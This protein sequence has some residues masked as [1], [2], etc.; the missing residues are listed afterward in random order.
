L[1][2]SEG[3]DPVPYIDRLESENAFFREAAAWSLGEIGSP[4]AARPLAGLLL[5]EVRAAEAGGSLDNGGV[6]RAVAVAIRRIGASEALYAVVRALCAIGRSRG[7]DRETVEELV[8]T[9]AEVG[10]PTAIR[11]AVEKVA[12][13]ARLKPEA[14]PGLEILCPTLFGCLGL[15]GDGAIQTLR[16]IARAGPAP[17][18]AAAL[19]ALDL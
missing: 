11:E 18:R 7:A 15:C 12:Q 14:T 3:P 6:V 10:G 17:L 13:A 1:N 9:L 5:R 19:S 16:R 2:R 8:E 4:R